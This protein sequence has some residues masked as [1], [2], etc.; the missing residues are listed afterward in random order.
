M[1]YNG[2]RYLP[3]AFLRSLDRP[4]L[5]WLA[6]PILCFIG[7]APALFGIL[8]IGSDA[9]MVSIGEISSAAIPLAA[10]IFLLVLNVGVDLV[11][12]YGFSRERPWARE[13]FVLGSGACILYVA[14]TVALSGSSLYSAVGEITHAAVWWVIQTWYLFGYHPVRR[15]YRTLRSRSPTNV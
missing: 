10:F 11:S 8:L 9:E 5:I 3:K 14:G 1:N 6:P 2:L 4:F 13:W 7:L 15:Y 12:A